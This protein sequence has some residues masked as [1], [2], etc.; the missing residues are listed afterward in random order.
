LLTAALLLSLEKRRFFL[1]KKYTSDRGKVLASGEKKRLRK[2]NR[3][4][5]KEEKEITSEKKQP[6]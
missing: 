4:R 5:A 1:R 3:E 2:R 6:R